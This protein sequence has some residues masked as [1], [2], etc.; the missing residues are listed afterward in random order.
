MTV[1]GLVFMLIGAAVVAFCVKTMVDGAKRRGWQEAAGVVR[2]SPIATKQVGGFTVTTKG[3]S[4]AQPTITY[5]YEVGGRRH[6]GRGI[7][8]VRET[9]SFLGGRRSNM[10]AFAEGA[11]IPVYYDPADPSRSATSRGGFG[12][13]AI[14]GIVVGLFFVLFGWM[15]MSI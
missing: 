14:I 3:W 10:A 12:C 7:A 2:Q 11:P 15:F 9:R 8:L 6:T 5:E 1:F 4:S 13:A